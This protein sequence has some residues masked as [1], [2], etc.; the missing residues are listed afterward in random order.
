MELLQGYVSSISNSSDSGE[1]LTE[2]HIRSVYIRIYSQVDSLK[3]PTRED[4]AGTVVQSF[5]H[6]PG[7]TWEKL[8]FYSG[9]VLL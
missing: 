9:V 4:F 6:K 8:I 2:K 3:F 5:R 1:S 7:K